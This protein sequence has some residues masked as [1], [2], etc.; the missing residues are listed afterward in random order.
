MTRIVQ[1]NSNVDGVNHS[2]PFPLFFFFNAQFLFQ[3]FWWLN[4]SMLTLAT[5]KKKQTKVEIFLFCFYIYIHIYIY[6]YLGMRTV[7][8]LGMNGIYLCFGIYWSG[9]AW[10]EEVSERQNE[11][12]TD[13]MLGLEIPAEWA[14]FFCA[15]TRSQGDQ[16]LVCYSANCLRMGR[17][18]LCEGGGGGGCSLSFFGEDDDNFYK[19]KIFSKT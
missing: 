7:S 16:L 2:F 4:D 13:R 1:G 8:Y 12:K 3:C 6:I 11:I 14:W 19:K 5:V 9:T 18:L 15:K 10:C 17:G